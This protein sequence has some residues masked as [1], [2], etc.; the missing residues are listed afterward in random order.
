MR[1]CFSCIGDEIALIG[2]TSK[3]VNSANVSLVDICRNDKDDQDIFNRL[4][5]SERTKDALFA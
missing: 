1:N 3:R 2:L 5:L 4:D